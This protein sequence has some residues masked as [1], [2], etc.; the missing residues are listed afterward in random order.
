MPA[1]RFFISKIVSDYDGIILAKI[2]ELLGD[3]WPLDCLGWMYCIHDPAQ[4]RKIIKGYKEIIEGINDG[5]IQK[6]PV[7]KI[8]K[9][10]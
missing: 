2:S 4:R 8:E 9:V 3:E 10:L 6:E 5:T 1:R 7:K